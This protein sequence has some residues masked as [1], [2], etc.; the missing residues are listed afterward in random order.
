MNVNEHI[1]VQ[2]SLKMKSWSRFRQDWP[3]TRQH[4]C[5]QIWEESVE[6]IHWQECPFHSALGNKSPTCCPWPQSHPVLSIAFH[7]QVTSPSRLLLLPVFL[8]PTYMSM[9]KKKKKKKCITTHVNIYNINLTQVI[10]NYI[11]LYIY[12]CVCMYIDIYINFP[13]SSVTL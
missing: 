3:L 1:L 6:P 4:L 11:Q 2:P 5:Q 12:V 7:C 8:K 10:H 9:L 13:S